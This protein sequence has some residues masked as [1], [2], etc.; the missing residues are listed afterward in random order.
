MS[1]PTRGHQDRHRQQAPGAARDPPPGVGRLQAVGQGPRMRVARAGAMA[2][3]ALPQGIA[4]AQVGAYARRRARVARQE[5]LDVGAPRAIEL[6][7]DV[8][9][10]LDIRDGVR[11]S[12]LHDRSPAAWRRGLGKMYECIPQ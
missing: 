10:Q 2:R 9:V 1:R 3:G 11:G 4:Q 7:V 12:A 5:G 6:A 8:G